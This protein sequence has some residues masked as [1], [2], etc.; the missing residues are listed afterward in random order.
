MHTS[1]SSRRSDTDAPCA[2]LPLITRGDLEVRHAS[3]RL[4]EDLLDVLGRLL[5]RRQFGAKV[6]IDRIADD[7]PERL[8]LALA[9]RL[10]LLPLFGGQRDLR[11]CRA[12][13]QYKI[14]QA[15]I[16]DPVFMNGH[17]LRYRLE[18]AGCS[19]HGLA[20]PACCEA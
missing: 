16:C 10:E 13:L 12:H 18:L 4:V 14:P 11:S 15:S 8:A 1:L 7:L 17:A 2:F 5:C 19:G 9:Q 6:C 3:E 20:S